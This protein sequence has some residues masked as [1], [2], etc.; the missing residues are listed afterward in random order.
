M[1]EPSRI[2]EV[3]A[4]IQKLWEQHPDLRLGQLLLN[5]HYPATA[6]YFMEDDEI[7]TQ[8]ELMYEKRTSDS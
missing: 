8:L 5:I 1:R 4:R 2:P 7:V 3:M 6:I